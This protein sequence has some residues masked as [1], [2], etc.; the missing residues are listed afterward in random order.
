VSG[1]MAFDMLDRLL[2]T[3]NLW[4][5][6]W[7]KRRVQRLYRKDLKEARR[8]KRGRDEV[9][10]IIQAEMSET[11]FIDD[12]ILRLVTQHLLQEVAKNLLPRPDF[13]AE[14]MWVESNITGRRHLSPEG[15]SELRAKI[16]QERR[17]RSENVRMWLVGLTGVIGALAGLVAVLFRK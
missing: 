7:Q 15:I 17:E 6:Q 10:Q 4:C 12:E 8:Q 9:E 13:S 2:F 11:D 14:G 16:R 5:L 1:F 3:Y